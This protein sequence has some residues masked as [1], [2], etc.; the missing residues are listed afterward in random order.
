MTD[1]SKTTD[2]R[3]DALRTQHKWFQT[4]LQ[5]W[6]RGARNQGGLDPTVA[7]LLKGPAP[8]LQPQSTDWAG[9]IASWLAIG[10]FI[11]GV[12]YYVKTRKG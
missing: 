10:G 9:K 3:I 11:A 8:S 5:Y 2:P 1:T 6:Q 12:W 7:A 4:Q